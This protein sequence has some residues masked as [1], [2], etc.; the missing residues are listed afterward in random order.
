M[1][2]TSRSHTMYLS[3]L[4]DMEGLRVSYTGPVTGLHVGDGGDRARRIRDDLNAR[5]DHGR[6]FLR[7][8]LPERYHYRADPRIGDVVI[9][10]EE[11]WTLAASPLT[12]ALL[13]QRWGE[14]GWD[15][16]FS[17]MHGLF[18]IAG[19]T[20]LAGATIP[21]VHNVDVYPLMVEL[22]G[23]A[24]AEN[25]DGRAGR[26]RQLVEQRATGKKPE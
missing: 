23:L 19:P 20:I 14:H 4:I 8:E 11:P 18:V 25:I 3:S 24:P 17:S 5:L 16:A 21:D 7:E 26:I 15:P 12:R 1:T 6:A 10:M 9:V 2:E 22:L 13:Q